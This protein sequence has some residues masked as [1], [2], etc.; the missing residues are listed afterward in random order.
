M[1]K[2]IFTIGAIIAAIIVGFVAFLLAYV[3][4][5]SFIAGLSEVSASETMRIGAT[6]GKTWF[7]CAAFIIGAIAFVVDE[8]DII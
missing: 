3:L 8:M 2:A 7:M 1:K 6:Y 5:C 4:F